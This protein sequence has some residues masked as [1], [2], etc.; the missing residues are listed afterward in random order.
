MRACSRRRTKMSRGSSTVG[1]LCLLM[2]LLSAAPLRASDRPFV[3]AINDAAIRVP[4]LD[5]ILDDALLIG[6]GDINALVWTGGGGV[7]MVLTK[8][9]VWDARLL[10]HR[11]PP[12]PTLKLIKQLGK[13]GKLGGSFVLPGGAKYDGKD[14]YHVHA[15]PCPRACARL[16]L[17]GDGGDKPS[18]KQIRAQGMRNNW[19]RRDNVTVMSICGRQ[20][21][22]NGYALEPLDLATDDYNRLRVRLSGTENARYFIDV[23]TPAG[24][25]ILSSKWIETP[26][27]PAE[28]TFDLPGGKRIGK[29]I[30]YTW[31]EDN[32]HAENRFEGVWFEGP[33]GKHA[34]D[35]TTT[36][37]PTC[38]GRLDL[39]RAVATVDGAPG[40]PPKA[41]I[42][43]LPDSNVF[44]IDSPAEAR[45]IPLAN[46]DL[47]A[48]ET[49][50]LHGATWIRQTIPG[51]LDWPGMAF[52]VALAQ[53]GDRKAVAIVTSLERPDNFTEWAARL[54]SGVLRTDHAKLIA[55]HEK[56]WHGFWSHSGLEI[57]DPLLQR[58]WYRGLYFLRCV[59]KPHVVCPGL[60]ASLIN[61]TPAWHGDY[62]TNYNL[63]QTFWACYAANHA[64]LAEPY[65]RVMLDY[66]PRARWLCKQVF[67]IDGAYYPHVLFAYEPEHPERCKSVNGRQYIHHV[68]GMTI[69]VAG[70]SI[71]PV[72]W[73]YKYKPSRELLQTIYPMVRDV[74]KFYAAFVER[75]E[76][77]AGGKVRLGPSVSPE[78]WGWSKDL[79]RNY[80]CAFDIA[81]ARYTL[82]AAIEGAS[83]LKRDAGLVERWRAA[84][85]KLPDYPLH[86]KGEPIV[87]DVAGAPPITYN[88]SVPATPVF[89]ADVITFESPDKTKALFKRTI[90]GL[91]WNGNNA[92]VMLAISRARLSMPG[93]Q[94]WLREEVAARTRP[95]GTMTLNRLK[96]H[97]GFN[98]FGHYTEQFGTGMAVSELLVQSAGDVIRLFPA[99]R[100][101][102]TAR[103]ATLRTQGGFLVYAEMRK[104]EIQ[105]FT[106]VST[107][108]GTLRVQSP[109]PT[110]QVARTYG[111]VPRVPFGEPKPVT[112]GPNRIA[113]VKTGLTERL[114]FSPVPS[115][116]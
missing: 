114:R 116:R 79:E 8:N 87:V 37:P 103:V 24:E 20:G 44:L 100:E 21:A 27:K 97:H 19:E 41:I 60:F 42:R 34:V 82:E 65:D 106:I 76:P 53:K 56:A 96:P 93:T 105:P 68:W 102:T 59:S 101:G 30:L 14:S 17:G 78:H 39:L 90:D 47:P 10:T 4:T 57:D 89:P 63:Q 94:D 83:T 38:P 113:V 72:W 12:L 13:E 112:L 48:A 32:K 88:I 84:I 26:T 29:L 58:T 43:A 31:T 22:S 95:N 15:F 36:S 110:L 49:G 85:T 51:D 35:L 3:D 25:N 109:W 18:W 64:D 75:C 71:Q 50:T 77:A 33:K 52:A 86:G 62:H 115:G 91:K 99:V 2:G 66:L 7:S 46:K 92:T 28:R 40:G 11:D 54:A 69:G 5:S 67:D 61:D 6:N 45:L 23:M 9:D 70:F 107:V 55:G 81:M 98:D 111:P 73:H 74:A 104:G 1:V 108:G 16:Q 80:D